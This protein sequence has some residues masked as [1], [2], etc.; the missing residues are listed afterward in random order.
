[1]AEDAIPVRLTTSLINMITIRQIAE[2]AGV[3]KSTVSLALRRDP[4][5]STKTIERIGQ[6][7]N[8]LGYRPN[9]LVTANMAAM[10]AGRRQRKVHANLAYFYDHSR[11]TPYTL[12]SFRGASEQAAALGFALEAVPYNAPDITPSRLLQILRNRSVQGILIGESLTPIPHIEFNWDE[13]AVV[14]IGYTLQNPRVDRI[15]FDHAENL[16]RLFHELSLRNYKRVGLAMRSDLDNRVSHLP[17][18]SYLSYQ[19]EKHSTDQIPL[20]V[21][22]DHWSKTSFLEWF[23]FNDPDCVITIGND[24]GGWLKDEGIRIPED[25]GLFSVWGIDNEQPQFYSHFNV[26]LDLLARTAI[27]VLTDRLNS[28]S[29]GVPLRRR[30]ILLSSDRIHRQSLRPIENAL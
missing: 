22:S 27:E 20:F 9:P 7:A 16:A 23:R 25:V 24:A 18:A 13:F 14:A 6:I 15:G 21:E 17:T 11:G 4:S 12:S 19:F 1:M 30:S 28:N 3:S 5:C 8:E 10:R 26:S 29:R 2:K